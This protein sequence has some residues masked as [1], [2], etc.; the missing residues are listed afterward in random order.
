MTAEKLNIQPTERSM[1]RMTTTKTMPDREHA[2]EAPIREQLA[3]RPRREEVRVG[4]ADEHDE[5]EER[6]DDAGL[7]GQARPQRAPARPR[8]MLFGRDRRGRAEV[9][10]Q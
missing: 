10:G 8:L 5:Q 9:P 3:E 7:L 4:D 6:D 1:S 2:G